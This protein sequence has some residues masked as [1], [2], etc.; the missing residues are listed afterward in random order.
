MIM[1]TACRDRSSTAG[2]E[3]ASPT[4]TRVENDFCLLPKCT[5]IQKPEE[6]DD[7]LSEAEAIGALDSIRVTWSDS[8]RRPVIMKTAMA[9]PTFGIESLKHAEDFYGLD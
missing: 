3:R 2:D 6:C 7:S 9:V 1:S 8:S 4:F 5:R